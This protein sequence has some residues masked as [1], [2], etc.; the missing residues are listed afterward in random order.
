M[1]SWLLMSL[2]TTLFPP[3]RPPL[4]MM[5]RGRLHAIATPGCMVGANV[6][7]A[8]VAG[9]EVAQGPII[10]VADNQRRYGSL[11]S[12]NYT[13]SKKET[14]VA[15]D[16][17]VNTAAI[18]HEFI[19]VQNNSEIDLAQV[20]VTNE[21]SRTGN[22][23]KV[24]QSGRNSP[25]V[26]TGYSLAFC[27][28]KDEAKSFSRSSSLRR[29]STLTGDNVNPSIPITTQTNRRDNTNIGATGIIVSDN[30]AIG[31]EYKVIVAI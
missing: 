26:A 22:D 18:V 8:V 30:R 15:L 29:E 28:A 5:L 9:I 27:A 24:V 7:R 19:A 17:K 1:A 6:A 25:A 23:D 16:L 2:P 11:S 13:H 14:T 21:L 20:G 4:T 3:R 10:N 31:A 12:I